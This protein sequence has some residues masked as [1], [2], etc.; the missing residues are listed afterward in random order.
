MR[1]CAIPFLFTGDN[2]RARDF[3]NLDYGSDWYHDMQGHILLS[4]GKT[5]QAIASLKS[6]SDSTLAFQEGLMISS[7]T[8][9]SEDLDEIVSRV[10]EWTLQFND[11]ET[12]ASTASFFAF[13]GLLDESLVFLERAIDGNYCSYPLIDT[14]A[15]WAKLR[16]DPRYP[17]VLEDARA[18]HERF[19]VLAEQIRG[20][21]TDS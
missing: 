15:L 6:A 18:C 1:S 5:E 7:C 4:E 19:R 2:E 20:S 11:S 17:A 13:C 8:T 12:E 14:D 9:G 21:A 16:D 10:G 3:L